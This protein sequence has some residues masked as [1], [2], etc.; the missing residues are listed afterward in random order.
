MSIIKSPQEVEKM[1]L[2]GALLSNCLDMLVDLAVPGVSAKK[3]DQSA[4]EFIRDNGAIPAFK[5]YGKDIRFPS[6][7]CFSRNS[8]LVHGIP[9]AEDIIQEGDIIT[10]D[11][12]LSIDGWF[13]DAARLFGA[14]ELLEDD[15]D[16]ILWTNNALDAGIAACV[17]GKKLADICC[18]IQVM[19]GRSPYYNVTQFTGH[20]I[21]KKMH[22]APEVPNF[23]C[24]SVVDLT[25]EPG[26]VF[27]LEPML[28]KTNAPLAVLPDGWTIVTRD[29]SRAT[30]IEQMVLITETEP[31]VL[32]A[33]QPFDFEC[34]QEL[35][36]PYSLE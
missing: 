31:E 32:T 25:L 18:A 24:R 5:N 3:L 2:S 35:G 20:A 15:E 11:C 23:K 22:E 26:M 10:I 30:H 9:R 6:S 16:I 34:S 33:S 29:G 14:G 21:G 8:V 19:I 36:E 17:A 28:K 7:I 12:G 1:R 13:A 4:E 27:C